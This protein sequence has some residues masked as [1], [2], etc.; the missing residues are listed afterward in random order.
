MLNSQ[1]IVRVSAAA[2]LRTYKVRVVGQGAGAVHKVRQARWTPRWQPSSHALALNATTGHGEDLG[3]CHT[4]QAGRQAAQE[5]GTNWRCAA[6]AHGAPFH[7]ILP[8]PASPVLHQAHTGAASCCRCE[9]LVAR[10]QRCEGHPAE[11]PEGRELEAAAVRAGVTCEAE[12]TR[13]TARA[14]A[15]VTSMSPL[16]QLA[17]GA[18][19]A[20]PAV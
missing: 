17:S 10:T 2:P 16:L 12:P 1:P 5:P 8:P 14:F 9:A 7:P 15:L 11:R 4:C 19:T 6:P 20:V 3:Q 13:R 18:P